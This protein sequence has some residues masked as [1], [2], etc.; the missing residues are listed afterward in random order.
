MN[1]RMLDSKDINGVTAFLCSDESEFICGQDIVV[2]DG[3]SF[4]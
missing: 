3:F 1:K 2:D 4:K